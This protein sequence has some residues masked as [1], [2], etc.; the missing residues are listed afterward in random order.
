MKIFGID[1]SGS[2]S[3][4]IDGKTFTGR[5]VTIVGDQVIVDG[6]AQAGTLV[7]PV[8]VTVNGDAE[9][10]TTTSGNIVVN[11]GCYRVKS[12]SG[13]IECRDVAGDVETTSGDVKCGTV[14]GSVNTISGNIRR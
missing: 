9:N 6:V 8:N 1:L 3:V 12:T 7:G 5:S 13:D 2:G 14:S 11:G 4:T 10:V